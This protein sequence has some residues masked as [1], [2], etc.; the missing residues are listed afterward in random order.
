MGFYIA[1]QT[2]KEIQETLNAPYEIC[3]ILEIHDLD[4]ERTKQMIIQKNVFIGNSNSCEV[5]K[6]RGRESPL[7]FSD[8]LKYHTHPMTSY[9]Y[10]SFEDLFSV[11]KKRSDGRSIRS[12]I[13]T[14]WGLWILFPKDKKMDNYKKYKIRYNSSQKIN[15]FR[16]KTEEFK[17]S[18]LSKTLEDVREDISQYIDTVNELFKNYITIRLYPWEDIE[19]DYKEVDGLV[20]VYFKL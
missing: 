20:L 7:F 10:P 2:L 17:R 18:H 1:E 16:I 12:F 6:E 9:S 13:F 14:K 8:E 15:D 11:M 3:G 5:P 4:E 19:K